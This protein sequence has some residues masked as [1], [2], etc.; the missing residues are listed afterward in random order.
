MAHFARID[1][2]SRVIDVLPVD[3]SKCGGGNF[4][5]SEPIGNAFLNANGFPGVWKQTSYNNSF[6]YNFACNGMLYDVSKDAF[7]STT[8]P[9]PGWTFDE[10]TLRWVGP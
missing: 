4:P 9:G 7:Y 5:S 2:S 1:N 10:T 6:R 3:N 8:S